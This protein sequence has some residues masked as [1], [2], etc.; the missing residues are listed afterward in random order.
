MLAFSFSSSFHSLLNTICS[1]HFASLPITAIFKKS[2]P[3]VFM[4]RGMR[5][6]GS[7]GLWET[8]TLSASWNDLALSWSLIKV[9]KYLCKAFKRSLTLAKINSNI[10]FIPKKTKILYISFTTRKFNWLPV[11]L[12]FKSFFVMCQGKLLTH[13]ES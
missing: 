9:S 11:T 13:E 7:F 12:S 1:K 5:G 4:K 10:R 6:E 3:L 2:Y 8:N